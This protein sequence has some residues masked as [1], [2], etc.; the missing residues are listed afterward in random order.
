MTASTPATLRTTV[1]I[2]AT[3]MLESRLRLDAMR[4]FWRQSSG[5]VDLDQTAF[6]VAGAF[7]GAATRSWMRSG[8]AAA[9]AG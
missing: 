1:A 6:S 2:P 8:S 4:Q 3:S 5:S 7:S 9:S